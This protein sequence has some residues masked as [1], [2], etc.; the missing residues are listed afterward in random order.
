MIDENFN[1]VETGQEIKILFQTSK[2]FIIN[3]N[4][5]ILDLKNFI[6]E[7]FS[8]YC[9]DFNIYVNEYDISNLDALNAKT[10]MN[11]YKSNTIHVIPNLISN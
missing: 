7:T 1:E 3:D 2:S 6:F 5:T 4:T 10:T 11:Y 9:N 8:K